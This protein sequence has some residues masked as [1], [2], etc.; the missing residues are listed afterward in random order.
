MS[1]ASQMTTASKAYDE[2]DRTHRP[3]RE[4][5]SRNDARKQMPDRLSMDKA[6]M[7]GPSARRG[8]RQRHVGGH[9]RS[10]E[11]EKEPLRTNARSRPNEH[12][13]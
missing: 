1:V 5:R 8:E 6:T 2:M 4:W 9:L 12:G 10:N 13:A 11:M 7:R 3:V